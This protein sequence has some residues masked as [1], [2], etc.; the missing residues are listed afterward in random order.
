MAAVLVLS[1]M[2]LVSYGA[3]ANA[4]PGDL[5]AHTVPQATDSVVENELIVIYKNEAVSLDDELSIDASK[6][7]PALQRKMPDAESATLS[8]FGVVDQQGFGASILTDQEAALLTLDDGVD[9]QEL[10]EQLQASSE[11]VVAQPNY[12]YGIMSVNDPYATDGNGQQSQ[13]YLQADNVPEAWTFTQ[14]T[15]KVSI[16]LLDTGINMD[17][18]DLSSVIDRS[19]AYDVVEQTSLVGNSDIMG[20]GTLVAGVLAAEANNGI[21]IAGVSYNASIIPIKVFDNEGNCTTADLL[22]AY[23]HLDELASDGEIANLKVINL[24]LGYYGSG[25]DE[26]DVAL[27]QAIK[28]M[29]DQHGV[30]T[31][32]AG[33]NGDAAGNPQTAACYPADFDEC[34]S[35]TALNQEGQEATWSDRNQSK[36]IS[37]PGEAILSTDANG[38][39]SSLT[40]T[41]MAAPQVSAAAALLWSAKPDLSVD[42]VESALKQ[43]A[44][45]IDNQASSN[46]SAGA[47]DVAASLH[48][49]CPEF[50]FEI[51]DNSKNTAQNVSGMTADN[52]S[53]SKEGSA[54]G[55]TI[56]DGSEYAVENETN[57]EQNDSSSVE[58]G[59]NER[60]S[61]NDLENDDPANSWRYVDGQK[62]IVSPE[63]TTD[64][65]SNQG[66]SA[67]GAM[68]GVSTY[69]TWFKRNGHTTYSWRA[70]PTD[71][72]TDISIPNAKRIG[73]DVSSYQGSIDW[74]KVKADGISFAIIRCGSYVRANKEHK[75]DSRFVENVKNAQAN[76][77][78]VGVYIYSYAE[79]VTGYQRSSAQKEAQNTLAFLKQAEL[80]STNMSLPVYYDLED[81]SQAGFSA[82]KLGQIAK[83][84]CDTVAAE[85]YSVGIY[86][87]QNWWRNHLTDSVFNASN[88][89]RW[90][91]RYPGGDKENSSGVD[92]TDIWQFTDC[93]Q[94]SGINGNVD[95]N[96]D[97]AGTYSNRRMSIQPGDYMISVNSNRKFVLD[98]TGSSASDGANVALH[99]ANGQLNQRFKLTYDS[100]TGYYTITNTFSGKVLD[101]KSG[102][103]SNNANVQQWN[104]N[105]SLAQRWIIC[106]K[107]N[108][109][110]K[111]ASAINPD[112]V[113]DLQSDTIANNSNIQLYKDNDSKAQEFV[114]STSMPAGTTCSKTLENGLYK[115]ASPLSSS[116]VFDVEGGA[117][118]NGAN[119]RLYTGNN[120]GAQHFI[121]EYDRS[122][123]YYKLI[124]EKTGKV[125]DAKYG[126]IKSGTNI[127]Q[128]QSNNSLAQRWIISKE[129][130]GSYNIAS[131]ANVSY[132]LDVSGG[133]VNNG[134][135]IQL[136]KANRSQAQKFNITKII[137]YQKTIEP[138]VYEIAPLLATNKNID[139]KY[140]L[141]IS[142]TNIQLHQHNGTTAQAY[143]LSYESS[144]GYYIIKNVNSGKVMDVTWGNATNRANIQQWNS[145]NSL[146]QRWII[147]DNHDGSY[148]IKSALHPSYVLDVADGS[149][150]NGANIQ[151]YRSNG[152]KAQKYLFNL[153]K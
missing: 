64:E 62:V 143:E 139:V 29:R 129:R 152:T 91:A 123:G 33:G 24:S 56:V 124:N 27:Q 92:R 37:A 135:N 104:P 51:A 100:E 82:Q 65:Q 58:P 119:I 2:P 17:H 87:N 125:L 69:A 48:A 22:S 136:Y 70:N 11:I 90:A 57:E 7:D 53:G 151:L 96:V 121:A 20:H 76:G 13:Y 79:N 106:K 67:L 120:S 128:H 148:T 101:V 77:I 38:D 122:T 127:Q 149:T 133:V 8:E 42:Q 97:Y 15:N 126:E 115:I 130:D 98:V 74:K 16:A 28:N 144:T 4:T 26:S 45:A 137:A 81:S 110:Y 68:P 94:V 78:D 49:I 55:V 75:I 145:N 105:N 25:E 86:A 147:A 23:A 61:E 142:G 41:S 114:F 131:A 134:A 140:G 141:K 88:W 6:I 153:K 103:A 43:N 10:A 35:V 30:L 66:I 89:S 54:S 32:G 118:N 138:G 108:G 3:K 102:D 14:S 73:I 40:G 113:L 93:G 80:T 112:Y 36:D 150:R 39:Y 31:V 50:V 19:H 109:T 72:I 132:V 34:I 116:F 95:M 59:S 99:Q 46:G 60:E 83:T 107:S 117:D 146:A 1:L 5:P 84:F 21:G 111:I 9:P 63:A 52:A 12:S 18:P 85:G 47:L 44:R 71:A